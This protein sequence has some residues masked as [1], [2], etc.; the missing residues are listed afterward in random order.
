[1]IS[2]SFGVQDVCRNTATLKNPTNRN[3]IVKQTARVLKILSPI[4]RTPLMAGNPK[5]RS[6]R[7][8]ITEDKDS[9]KVDS[10]CG[11]SAYDEMSS[12]RCVYTMYA[13]AL[14]KTLK[15]GYCNISERMKLSSPSK[16]LLNSQFC[17]DNHFGNQVRAGDKMHPFL[18]LFYRFNHSCCRTSILRAI[19]LN[20]KCYSIM[21]DQC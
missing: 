15:N 21:N 14:E 7:I 16:C 10:H 8:K 12:P 13:T 1:M 18:N 6:K 20:S 3:C 5:M 2:N 19:R 11:E 4:K 17:A 9:V